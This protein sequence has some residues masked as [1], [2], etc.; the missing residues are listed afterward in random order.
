LIYQ[1][2][3]TMTLILLVTT[4]FWPEPTGTG[5]FAADLAV[6]LNSADYSVQVLTG[7]PHYPWW[8]IPAKYQANPE[9]W[10]NLDGVQIARENHYVPTKLNL[11]TRILFELSLI[12]SLR[13]AMLKI[14]SQKY[15]LVLAI[16]SSMAGGL[17]AKDISAKL[18]IPFGIVVHDLAGQFA[19]LYRELID[20]LGRGGAKPGL[21]TGIAL[22]GAR[23]DESAVAPGGAVGGVNSFDEYHIVPGF[24]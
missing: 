15:D 20:L 19:V 18:G 3:F 2:S 11:I 22:G 8:K 4:N 14:S 16:G 7:V 5:P 21:G 23:A 17:V 9:K 13:R 10:K 1:D 12:K 6:T 24:G